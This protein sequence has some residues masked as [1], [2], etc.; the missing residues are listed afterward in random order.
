MSQLLKKSIRIPMSV[1]R[2]I[3]KNVIQTPI[4]NLLKQNVFIKGPKSTT[5]FGYGGPSTG[6]IKLYNSVPHTYISKTDL[7]NC[8]M[9]GL[10][11]NVRLGMKW[12]LSVSIMQ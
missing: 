1:L 12:N 7:L 9:R 10:Q 5:C 2:E 6:R 4:I 3:E 11:L 8:K